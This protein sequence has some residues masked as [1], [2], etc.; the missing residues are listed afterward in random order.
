MEILA[1]LET[2]CDLRCILLLSVAGISIIHFSKGKRLN[3]PPGPPSIPLLGSLPWFDRKTP[4]KSMVTWAREYGP[5]FTCYI[6]RRR[7]ILLNDAELVRTLL[8]KYADVFSGRADNPVARR[9]WGVKGSVVFENGE[10]WK[11]HRKLI[12]TGLRHFGMG[13]RSLEEQIRTEAEQLCK[14]IGR[15]SG[16]FDPLTCINN[17]VSNIICSVCFG[18]RY[19]YTD[20]KFNELLSNLN[21]IFNR[22][23]FGKLE[24]VMPIILKLFRKHQQYVNNV[25]QFFDSHMKEHTDTFDKNN[26]RDLLDMILLQIEEESMVNAGSSKLISTKAIDS[27]WRSTLMLFLAGTDTTTNTIMWFLQYMI[28]Y[29]EVQQRITTEI[30]NATNGGERSLTVGD[31]LKVPYFEATICEVQRL[32]N[33]APGVVMHRTTADFV[34]PNDG[35]TIPANTDFNVNL[36]VIHTDPKYWKDPLQFKPER[37]LDADQKTL[38]KR[39]AFMP[40]GIGRRACLGE[41]LAKME[42]Y[43]FTSSLLQRFKVELPDGASRPDFEPIFGITL[44]PQPFEMVVKHR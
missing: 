32:S 3:L 28:C 2:L 38:I 10:E 16:K 15:K 43:I 25:I 20:A 31:K 26:I 34:T 11:T 5:I 4:L 35:Y 29:P 39:D 19:E 9:R 18:K 36:R 37:F 7:F 41:R 33:V 13:K 22:S 27:L 44:S 6:G 21:A 24:F 40:F 8:I 12:V 42:I 14:E 17:A 30:D 23:H 1:Y